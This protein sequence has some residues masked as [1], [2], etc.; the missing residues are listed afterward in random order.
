MLPLHSKHLCA[1][2]LDSSGGGRFPQAGWTEAA[3]EVLCIRWACKHRNAHQHGRAGQ[4]DIHDRGGRLSRKGHIFYRLSSDVNSTSISDA[5][6]HHPPSIPRSQLPTYISI[7]QLSSSCSV[8]VKSPGFSPLSVIMLNCWD[9]LL[10]PLE[11][12]NHPLF[13][14]YLPLPFPAPPCP[15]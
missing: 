8:P 12:P 10:L 11:L 1:D 3:L 2:T 13:F 4:A 6:W 9:Q 15:Y 14:L 7:C 5:K